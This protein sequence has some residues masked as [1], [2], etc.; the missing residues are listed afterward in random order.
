MR[1]ARL[2]VVVVIAAG[3]GAAAGWGADSA[4]KPRCVAGSLESL[5][6]WQ[7]TFVAV[8]RGRVEAFHTPRRGRLASFTRENVNGARNVF[9]VRAQL[10]DRRCRARWYRVQLPMRPNGVTGWIRASDVIVR[11]VTTRIIVDLSD[12]RVSL[13]ERGRRV[14]SVTAA[15]GSPSTPTPVGSFYVNQRLIPVNPDGPFGPAAIGISAFSEV[16]TW[17]PQGGPVAIHGTNRPD[18]I[19]LRASN[20]CIRIRND[21]LRRLFR[22]AVAG[23]PVTIRD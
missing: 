11:P 12:R 2:L 4:P 1:L 8:A 20:G 6:T 3:G 9:A 18:L 5:V 19:G 17:W 10:V 7:R 22:A 13:F 16:L 15:V 14:L 23:T 21:V